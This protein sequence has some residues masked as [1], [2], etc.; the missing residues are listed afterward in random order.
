[1]IEAGQIRMRRSSFAFI[2][3]VLPLAIATGAAAEMRQALGTAVLFGMIGPS[4]AWAAAASG[5]SC[6]AARPQAIAIDAPAVAP[7]RAIRGRRRGD[8]D[9]GSR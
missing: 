8:R 2:F 4:S 7:F 5:V 1:V 6:T 9:G 3:G